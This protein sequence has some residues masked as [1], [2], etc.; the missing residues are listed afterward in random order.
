VIFS[1]KF[2]KI[3]IVLAVVFAVVLTI[4]IFLF[5][6]CR[7][8]KIIKRESSRCGLEFAFIKA[9]VCVESSFNEDSVSKA[10]AV[11]L[12]QIMPST[13]QFV[14]ERNNLPIGDLFNPEYNV[15]V[16]V[17]YLRYLF[18]KFEDERVV[19]CAYN[20]G[21]GN[22]AEWLKNTNYSSD[23]KTLLE[24]PFK[25]TKNYVDKVLKYKR[26]YSLFKIL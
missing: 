18:D 1:V 14:A 22:V 7:Y 13:A 12:M 3:I 21:E 4:A 23:G 9:V 26:I 2:K 19:L 11:G 6:F 15:S 17:L 16:G 20:A 24:I 10:G 8:D 5:R 25:E